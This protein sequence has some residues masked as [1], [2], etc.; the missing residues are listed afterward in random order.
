MQFIFEVCYFYTYKRKIRYE[1]QRAKEIGV[2]KEDE[3][4]KFA[5]RV[6]WGVSSFYHT[7]YWSREIRDVFPE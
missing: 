1:N 2:H 6:V 3:K 5:I 7:G 4:S